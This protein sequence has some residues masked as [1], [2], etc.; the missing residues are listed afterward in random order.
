MARTV[1]D[2]FAETL[3]AAGVK[4]IYGIVGDTARVA[5][6]SRRL[7]QRRARLH[8]ALAEVDR[9]PRLRHR[10]NNPNFAAMA[11]AAGVC[12]IR[13]EDPAPRCRPHPMVMNQRIQI[14]PD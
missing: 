8:R 6:E 1:A 14:D 12:G 5:G 9:H 10:L 13:L 2:Q 3:T 7:Q 11:E 4:R